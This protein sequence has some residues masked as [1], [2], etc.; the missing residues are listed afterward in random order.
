MSRIWE[1]QEVSAE[2]K[3]TRPK[4]R[5]RFGGDRFDCC[6][7]QGC[8]CGTSKTR[9][10]GKAKVRIDVERV[11]DVGGK[12]AKGMAKLITFFMACAD[13]IALLCLSIYS[14]ELLL[15]LESLGNVGKREEALV[16]SVG[17]GELLL[18]V[19]ALG[20]ESSKGKVVLFCKDNQRMYE[21][22]RA[23]ESSPR[24]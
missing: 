14:L 17:R 21:E 23:K 9:V 11:D 20:K 16:P 13:H 24:R 15:L 10:E 19:D 1:R 4:R 5:K 7:Q 6:Q 18:A 2:R 22:R 8:F 3:R 12:A